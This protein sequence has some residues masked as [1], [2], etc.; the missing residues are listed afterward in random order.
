MDQE[1]PNMSNVDIER[2][3]SD[4]LE[5]DD[6][7]DGM[8]RL[9][10][11]VLDIV[12]PFPGIA[13]VKGKIH[14][15]QPELWQKPNV[16]VRLEVE[17]V[18]GKRPISRVY[19]IRSYDVS[20]NIVEIDFVLHE[21][22]SPAMRWLGQATPGSTIMMVGPRPHFVPDYALGKKALFFADDTAIPAIYSILQ[23][24][25]DSAK[26]I[27][28]IECSEPSCAREL[29]D[30]SGVEK[31]IYIRQPNEHAGKTGSLVRAA[32]SVND[33]ADYQIWVA[34]E[35]DETRAIRKHFIKDC[36]VSKND[37]KAIGYWRYGVTSSEI[38]VV[39]LEYYNN[40]RAKGEG[41]KEFD[42][43]DLPI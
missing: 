5:Q 36:G 21:G 35:R 1:K 7:M 11:T 28:H 16:A 26:G 4:V 10:L 13:R 34:C 40:L 6:H 14:P 27:I 22:T 19:T 17:E 20:K 39:R 8:E 32:Q 24:W 37:I 18:T 42:E 3:A 41:L 25:P 29:P 30:I 23:Q 31:N 33:A 43:F 9:E 38:D 12:R 15:S 2:D